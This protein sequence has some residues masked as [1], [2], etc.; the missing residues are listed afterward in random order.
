MTDPSIL[1]PL[2]NAL[3]SRIPRSGEVDRLL[4]PESASIREDYLITALKTLARGDDSA[5]FRR[6]LRAA[7]QWSRSRGGPGAANTL[8][9]RLE[10]ALELRR[11]TLALYDHCLHIIGGGQKYGL[12]LLDAL[13]E[14]FDTTILTHRP[15]EPAAIRDWYGLELSRCRYHTIDLP[16]YADS[17]AHIDPARINRRM[18]N[19]FHRVSRMSGDFDLF[20]NNSMNEMVF[21][22]AGISTMVCHFPERRPGA[23]FYSDRYD[24][25]IYNSEYTA[26][27]IERKWKFRPHVHIYPPVD[28]PPEE[29]PLE[30][31][32]LI[33][34]V[35]RFEQGGSKKQKEMVQAFLTLRRRF[36]EETRDW[37]LVLAGG[38]PDGNPY[39]DELRAEIRN[40][41]DT[42]I[43][44]RVNINSDELRSLYLRAS[45]FWHLC[46]LHQT[47]PALVEHFGMTI[48]EAM[49][50]GIV[51]VVFDGGGQRE[52]VEPGKTGFRV[53]T[54]EEL[55]RHTRRLIREPETRRSCGLAALE[56]SKRFDRPR[57][58]SEVREFFLGRLHHYIDPKIP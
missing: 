35:A 50:N 42:H 30:K 25:V 10:V 31:D 2:E 38:S 15:M 52:I 9:S 36:P 19:P 27:W 16:E 14:D 39:L 48:G 56:A 54:L 47:D 58:T 17:G 28:M 11:P 45:I 37:H 4:Q 34:S 53:R 13:K 23:Y 46:G 49:Q 22:L 1:N 41:G 40:T 24:Y 12:M 55:I 44:L 32:P 33:L 7:A 3:T 51:P 18:P 43:R 29:K 57:F 20:I 5:G 26:G 6:A 8:V 21:P